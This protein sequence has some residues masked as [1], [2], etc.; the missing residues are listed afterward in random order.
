MVGINDSNAILLLPESSQ[1][2]TYAVIDDENSA[3]D[4]LD[5]AESSET[6]STL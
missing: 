3:I 5:A 2:M 1:Q 4:R 6:L